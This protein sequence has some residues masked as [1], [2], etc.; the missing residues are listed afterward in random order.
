MTYPRRLLVPADVAGA[1]HCVSRCV[2]RA[3]LCGRDHASGRSFEHRKQWVED[4]LIE[5]AW[6]FAVSLHAYAVMSNHVHA[7]LHVAPE[8]AFGWSDD[9]VAERWCRL[10][11]VRSNDAEAATRRRNALLASPER[12]ALCRQRLGSLSWFMRCLNEPIARRAN[13]EDACTGRFWEGRFKCQALLDEQAVLAAMAYVDLNPIRA[14]LTTRLDR[15][16]HT[17]VACRLKAI[18]DDPASASLALGPIAGLRAEPIAEVT[19]G[20]DIDLVDWTGR[21][22]RPGKRGSIPAHAPPALARL[23]LRTDRWTVEV[24]AV[25]SGYW[26]AIGAVQAML[27]RAAAMGQRWLKGVGTSR[28]LRPAVDPQVS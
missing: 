12:V 5:L 10:F 4:R 27:D 19:E 26:R 15:S 17:S 20:T 6:L 13:R 24:Q 7:V 21:Q 22:L 3:F 1:Y 11:P 8:A 2:R 9:E 25:G 23:G 28:A 18:G 14:G 16:T